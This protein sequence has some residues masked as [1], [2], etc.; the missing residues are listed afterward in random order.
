M[1]ISLAVL[2]LAATAAAAA[3][4]PSDLHLGVATCAS[5]TCH[6][7][8]KPA[9]KGDIQQNEYVTWSRFDPHAAAYRT[10]RDERSVAIAR[11]L[12]IG[13]AQEAK[14]CLDCHTDNTPPE[15]RGP[16]FQLDDGIGC[17]FCHGGAQAWLASHDDYPTV[18]HAD[19]VAKGMAALE[20]PAVRAA[21]C[22]ACHVGGGDRYASHRLMA[23]G[24]P[25]LSFELDTFTELWRTSGGREHYL[26][27]ADYA[28]RKPAP[29]AADVWA[30]GLV[31]NSR[32]MTAQVSA[33]YAKDGAL[34]DFALFNCYSCHRAMRLNDWQD[35]GRDANA[36][37]G[38][39]RFDDSV[40]AVLQAALAARPTLQSQL[41]GDTAAFQ[42]TAGASRD[43]VTKATATLDGTLAGIGRELSAHP[44]TAREAAQALD[45]LARGAGRG[46]YPDYV[47]A[48]QAAM[49]IAVLV[50][51]TGTPDASR[52]AFAELFKALENDERYDPQRFAR[53]LE[54]MRRR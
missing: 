39:L 49:G 3:N 13:K 33:R 42:K 11:R 41:R 34:P 26:R 8:A 18:S 4:Q 19:N 17:E 40:L 35:K 44:L 6:G 15:R 20:E 37:P 32:A 2:L 47:S 48:G 54:A 7:S 10:L 45:A 16:K 43:A 28:Q 29:Q 1:A 9:E 38:S 14:I 5:T 36:E 46:D 23:A 24:H 12:G 53:V 52:G 22:A 31:A 50:S 21:T 27:D 25:R 51:T 30:A